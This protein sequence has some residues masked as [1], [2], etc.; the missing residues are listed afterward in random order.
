M[1]GVFASA[2]RFCAIAR[3]ICEMANGT[4]IT[5]VEQD[6]DDGVFVTFS[7]GI[8]AGYVVEELLQLRPHREV[9]V[10]SL[11]DRIARKIRSVGCRGALL[12]HRPPR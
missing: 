11:S 4:T 1:E 7:D 6:G 2:H 8:M 10:D 9:V 12:R 5:K 3:T